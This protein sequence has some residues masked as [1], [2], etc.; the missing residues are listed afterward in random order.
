M[1][2]VIIGTGNV[3]T[4]FGRIFKK[5]GFQVIQVFGRN[6][7][8]TQAL[9]DELGAKPCIAWDLID[10][11][12]D[13]YLVAISD[14]ALFELD[15]HLRLSDQLV[16]HTAGS[17]SKNILQNI[18]TNYGVLYPLQSIRKEIQMS[19]E[20]PVLV[21]SNNEENIQKV[22]QIAKHVSPIVSV[23]SDETRKK[24]HIAGIFMNNFVNHLYAMAEDFCKKEN[25]EFNL[26]LPLVLET[27]KRIEFISPK[28]ILTGPAIR[29]D[30]TTINNHVE[31]LKAYPS[32][33]ILY[34]QLT[35]SIRNFHF[36]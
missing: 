35:E 34:Q 1:N 29:N 28:E 5:A 19:S 6:T 9:A 16:V 22:F 3:A 26:L 25:L 36:E 7:Q 17:V 27:A 15:Q 20:I 8:I 21:D 23:A 30:E 13:M 31:Y 14:N 33:Q 2:I 32:L 18:T 12:A 11:N 24:F 10:R 4:V